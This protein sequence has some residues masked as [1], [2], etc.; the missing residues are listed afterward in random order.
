[1]KS[2]TETAM[3][4]FVEIKPV[5][6]VSRRKLTDVEKSNRKLEMT[7]KKARKKFDIELLKSRKKPLNSQG[8]EHL[9]FLRNELSLAEYHMNMLYIK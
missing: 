9:I 3:D 4:L 7:V 8:K 6:K 1:M 2:K 5:K